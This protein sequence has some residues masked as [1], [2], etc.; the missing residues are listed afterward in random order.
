LL[1]YRRPARQLSTIGF[2]WSMRGIIRQHVVDFCRAY[3]VAN[4]YGALQQLGVS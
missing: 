4:P 2:T 1:N 3:H